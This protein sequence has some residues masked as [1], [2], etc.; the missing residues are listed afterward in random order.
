MF[1]HFN[2]GD[3]PGEEGEEKEEEVVV[4]PSHDAW[5]AKVERKEQYEGSREQRSYKIVTKIFFRNSR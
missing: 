4:E 3:V 2:L 5:A 1:K